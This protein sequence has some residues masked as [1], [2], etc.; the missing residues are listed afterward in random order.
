MLVHLR[1]QR[2]IIKTIRI[3][4][5]IAELF[6]NIKQIGFFNTKPLPGCLNI[7]CFIVWIL[8]QLNFF[9]FFKWSEK[10]GKVL[11]ILFSY[12]SF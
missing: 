4:W 3:I 11:N 5:Y 8:F 10:N 12:V 9:I 1:I 6:A 2:M 7:R